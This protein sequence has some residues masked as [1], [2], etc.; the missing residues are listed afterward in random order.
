MENKRIPAILPAAV[1]KR[2]ENIAESEGKSRNE[3]VRDA[4]QAYCDQ[5]LLE[6]PGSCLP[7]WAVQ[8]IDALCALLRRDLNARSDQLLSSMAIQLTVIQMILADGL[9]IHRADVDEYTRQA[10]D[11]LKSNNRL[12]R[13][14]EFI[15]RGG[16]GR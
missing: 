4:C 9:R 5:K 3:I 7:K 14:E 16:D 13:M 12:F 1:V 6:E 15:G 10:V 11:M 2:L 8:Q